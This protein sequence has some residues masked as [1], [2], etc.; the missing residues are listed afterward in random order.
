MKTKWEFGEKSME[1]SFQDWEALRALQGREGVQGKPASE[2][3][4]E[5]ERL[6][7]NALL[8]QVLFGDGLVQG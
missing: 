4:P 6:T 7:L 3:D 8:Y 2:K 1:R 5:G